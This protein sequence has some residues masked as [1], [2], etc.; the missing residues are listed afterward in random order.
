MS[1][2]RFKV[3]NWSQDSSDIEMSFNQL[4]RHTVTRSALSSRFRLL[5]D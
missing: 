2:L 1:V 3:G 4:K 5:R